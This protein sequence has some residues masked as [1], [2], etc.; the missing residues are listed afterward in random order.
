MAA[1]VDAFSEDWGELG[2]VFIHPPVGLVVRVL[3]YAEQCRAKGLLVVP[4]WHSSIFMAK[5]V[6]L[7]K[8]DKI[9]RV[10]KFK[11]FLH[12]APWISSNTFQGFPWFDFL[13]FE[14]HF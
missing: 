11:P 3:R 7:E 12:S 6:E 1:G 10:A 2:R 14:M 9:R 13:A 5:L 4:N 8:R